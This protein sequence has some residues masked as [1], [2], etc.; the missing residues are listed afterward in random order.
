[1]E[2]NMGTNIKKRRQELGLTQKELASGICTQ[3]Q[4]S[5]IEKGVLN[6]SS[7]VLFELSKRLL[8][9]MNYFFDTNPVNSNGHFNEIK[10]MIHQLKAQRNYTSIKYIVDNELTVNINRYSSYEH[11]YLL[12]H[13]GISLYHLTNKFKESVRM[14]EDLLSVENTDSDKLLNINV[15]TS[16][17]TIYQDEK[18]YH[19]AHQLYKEAW[20][21]LEEM[22]E[23]DDFETELK[24]LFGLSQALTYLGEYNESKLYSLR[25]ISICVKRN[26]LYMLPDSY[27]QTGNNLVKL[28]RKEEGLAYIQTA[29]TLFEIQGNTNMVNIVKGILEEHK[30]I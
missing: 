22:E 3:A 28:N 1:M 30:S 5:N 18:D 19:K 4:I 25:A 24:I 9:D 17:A 27:Y 23:T 2:L 15:K 21:Q 26:T 10:N 16:I 29:K 7:L 12:W 11:R 20:D 13:K 14:L 6:P 8:V